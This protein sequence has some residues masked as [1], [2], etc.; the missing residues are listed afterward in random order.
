MDRTLIKKYINNQPKKL[1]QNWILTRIKSNTK[2]YSKVKLSRRLRE[3]KKCL[4]P[5]F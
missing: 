1:S 2:V 4:V 5:L 3:T